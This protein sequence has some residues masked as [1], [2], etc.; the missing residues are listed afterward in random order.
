MK[1]INL[2]V[3]LIL[4]TAGFMASC[5]DDDFANEGIGGNK[6]SVAVKFGV[7]DM[8]NEAQQT[9]TRAAEGATISRAAF[10]QSLDMQ[11][12]ALEDLSTQ[13]LSVDGTDEV[14]LLETTVAGV[15]PVQQSDLQTRANISTAITENFSTLGYCGE[16]ESS[17]SNEPWFYNEE[18]NKDGVLTNMI[19]WKRE[20]PYGKFFGISPQI[21]SDYAK[22]KLSPKNYTGTP[23]VDFE[24]ESDVKNQKDLLV[25]NSGVVQFEAP[26]EKA[27][28]VPLK[29]RH[30]LTAVR[31][32]VGQNLSWNKTITKVDI[33]GA[34]TKGR[35]TLPVDNSGNGGKWKVDPEIG[36]C[37]L[38]GLNVSTSKEKNAILTGADGD[39]YTFYMIPQD[40]EGVAV[41]IC[42][43]DGST[44]NAMLKGKW[45]QG[46]TV[47]YSL[48]ERNSNWDYVLT[49]QS[50]ASYL[51]STQTEGTYGV[52]SYRKAPDRTQ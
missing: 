4:A 49:A 39:N 7:G 28:V 38:D 14:C 50:G 51:L 30:A 36:F 47:T 48:S 42:F 40:L 29:F 35:Y 43:S 19:V 17:I 37:T 1:R 52:M 18:T 46:T 27:P 22:L 25:A 12:I 41:N 15:N 45:Q 8:Q 20:F 24:V 3:L 23:Y 2:F 11:G 10:M 31:F 6:N 9:M 13:E 26:Y 16:T 34:K 21:K 44:L 33:V 32:K 5:T